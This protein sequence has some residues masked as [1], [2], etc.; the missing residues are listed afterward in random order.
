MVDASLLQ[1]RSLILR[2][3]VPRNLRVGKI[4]KLDMR[5]RWLLTFLLCG[6]SVLKSAAQDCPV[7][8]ESGAVVND[9]YSIVSQNGVL[10]AKFIMGHSV[11]KFGYTHYCYKYNASG[12]TVEA[13]TLRVNPGDQL[14]LEVVN[15]IK[16]GDS[17]GN[18]KEIMP[19]PAASGQTT[20]GDGGAMTLEST[21]V[22]FHG[23]NVPPTCHQDDVIDTLIQPGSPGFKFS[24]QIPTTEPPGLYWY[25]PH[26]HGFTEFQVN[27]GAAGAFVVEGM[28]KYRPEVKGLTERVFVIRQRYLVPWIP[29]P[30]QL[31]LNLQPAPQA[32]SLKPVIQMQEGDKEFWRVANASLQDFLELQVVQDNHPKDLELVALDG[33]PLAQTRIEKT[34]LLPPAGRAE[35]IVKAPAPGTN[36]VFYTQAYSTGPTGNADVSA[37]LANIAL[38]SG[39]KSPPTE[40]QPQPA[41]PTAPP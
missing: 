36:A 8:P 34:I 6:F 25:H 20:C 24:M 7:R 37:T 4:M 23:L 22:H 5:V 33:Y 38:V 39:E 29:G 35:F 40:T 41:V 28:E 30:Y 15:K 1:P 13:P 19:M 18:V 2:L 14:N 12:Q 26:V 10:S 32:E 27:G 3:L 21:N 11:D 17:K 9:A 16:E 31:T